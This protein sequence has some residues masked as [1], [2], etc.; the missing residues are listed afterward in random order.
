LYE[1]A[2]SNYHAFTRGNVDE[3]VGWQAGT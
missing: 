3:I 1:S 2:R